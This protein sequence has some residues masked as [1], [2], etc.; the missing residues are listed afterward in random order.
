[1]NGTRKL[2]YKNCMK[3]TA[4]R[5]KKYTCIVKIGNNPDMSAKC[6]KYRLNDLL[7]FTSFLDLKFPE[8]KWFNV[9]S[10]ESNKQLMNFT[11]YHKP[12]GKDG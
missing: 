6:L 7:K 9:F 11:K 1:M 2:N 3:K 10:K 12:M 8:W 5:P 4:N